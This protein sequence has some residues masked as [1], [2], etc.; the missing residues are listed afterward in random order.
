[1]SQVVPELA[2]QWP[3]P[4][5]AR[6]GAGRCLYLRTRPGKPHGVHGGAFLSE[7]RE[8]RKSFFSEDEIMHETSLV[9]VTPVDAHPVISESLT[10]KTAF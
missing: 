3:I 7:I 1:M 5:S 2:H 4:Y 9:A 8:I 10:H 6:E